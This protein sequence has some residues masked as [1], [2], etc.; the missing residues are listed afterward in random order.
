MNVRTLHENFLIFFLICTDIQA[1][2]PREQAGD[3][4]T[5]SGRSIPMSM[6][7]LSPFS[8]LSCYIISKSSLLWHEN[9]ISSEAARH[10]RFSTKSY[11]MWACIVVYGE[12]SGGRAGNT[13]VSPGF[14]GIPLPAPVPTPTSLLNRLQDTSRKELECSENRQPL[15]WQ[16]KE[17]TVTETEECFLLLIF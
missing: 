5:F 6:D 2:L 14:S 15:D 17:F 8:L 11:K 7:V 16:E 10:S 9:H 3:L 13:S 4:V 12:T 1:C